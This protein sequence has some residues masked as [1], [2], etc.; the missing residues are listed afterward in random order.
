M[1]FSADLRATIARSQQAYASSKEDFIKFIESA[2]RKNQYCFGQRE[3]SIAIPS[4]FRTVENLQALASNIKSL[5]LNLQTGNIG[6]IQRNHYMFASI[7]YAM[8]GYQDYDVE[9]Q[10]SRIASDSEKF[11]KIKLFI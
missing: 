6:N 5:G 2:I 11:Q 8:G 4:H 1:A 7:E 10:E 3:F 9:I